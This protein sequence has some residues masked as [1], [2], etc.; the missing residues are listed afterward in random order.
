MAQ[1]QQ[2]TLGSSRDERPTAPSDYEGQIGN[3][4]EIPTV[5]ESSGDEE[6]CPYCGNWYKE[7]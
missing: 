5:I 2:T 7:A 3:G 4:A 6:R 1:V